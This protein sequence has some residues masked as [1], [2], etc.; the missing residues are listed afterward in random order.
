[1]KDR[2]IEK[3]GEE[4]LRF[5]DAGESHGRGL[6]A[7][8]EGLPAN[9]PIK[10]EN[11]NKE[12]ARRQKGYGRGGRMKIEKDTVEIISGLNDGMTTGAPV[13]LLIQNRDYENWRMKTKEETF[14][15]IPRPGHA[16]LTGEFKYATGNL[17]NSIE[18]SSARETA[19]RTAVGAVC[20]EILRELGIEVRS[21]VQTLYGLNDTFCDLFDDGLYQLIEKSPMRVLRHEEEFMALVDS[22]KKN[23]DT[24]GGWVYAS[25]EGVMKGLGSFMQ[26]DRRLD[27]ILAGAL[28]S[29]QGVKQVSIGNPFYI[30]TGVRYQ[31]GIT[32][33]EGKLTR[34]SNHAGGIEGGISNGEP[35]EVY[36]YM[37][38]IPSTL[39]KL[40]S[41]DLATRENT[42][43]R[44]ERSDVTAVVPL[45]IV[46]EH[47][48]AFELLKEILNTFSRDNKEELLSAIEV[49]K[50]RIGEIYEKT[51]DY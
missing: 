40:P 29:I 1:M 7:V 3:R 8:L 22:A 39:R 21:K 2:Y 20:K 16:D 38:P 47:V 18:R 49:R 45:S 10:I 24:L 23:G 50:E 31:D 35:L 13:T 48:L 26:Y 11:I 12:L 15:T 5:L 25:C 4:M 32:Y 43:S 14:V 28:M 42:D 17:R 44:Y 34:T 6:C 51:T 41:V 27:G 46:V 30:A 19:I 9:F 36:C 33:E 37:K